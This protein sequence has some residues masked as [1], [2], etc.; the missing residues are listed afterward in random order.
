MLVLLSVCVCV[1]VFC[2]EGGEASL[3]TQT[4]SSINAP[5]C[6]TCRPLSSSLTKGEGSRRP[7][8]LENGSFWKVSDVNESYDTWSQGWK[9]RADEVSGLFMH[10]CHPLEG[11][12]LSRATG[13]LSGVVM[14]PLLGP[15]TAALAQGPPSRLYSLFLPALLHLTPSYMWQIL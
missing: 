5:I 8:S 4:L 12:A 7:R 13:E 11:W 2:I 14:S 15:D 10:C 1:L 6:L 3:L 9:Q